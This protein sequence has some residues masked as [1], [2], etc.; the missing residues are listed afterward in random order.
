M[1]LR[2]HWYRGVKTFPYTNA[3]VLALLVESVEELLVLQW[4]VW[5]GFF[6]FSFWI[7]T[8]HVYFV[9]V[10]LVRMQADKTL[11]PELVGKI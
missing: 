9:S 5:G 10:I 6:L 2:F 4:I 3:L 8:F 11:P 1:H 7:P